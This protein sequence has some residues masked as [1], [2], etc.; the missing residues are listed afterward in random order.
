MIERE[1]FL[2]L[3]FRKSLHSISLRFYKWHALHH[4]NLHLFLSLHASWF[5]NRLRKCSV[6]VGGVVGGWGCNT[7]GCFCPV[8]SGKFQHRGHFSLPAVSLSLPLPLTHT[9]T[10]RHTFSL[11]HTYTH[12]ASRELWLQGSTLFWGR[13][14]KCSVVDVTAVSLP[15][16][17]SS[18]MSVFFVSLSHVTSV[19]PLNVC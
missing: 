3:F 19:S 16:F 11:L 12:M 2:F 4:A 17:L 7:P 5:L 14:R 8:P 18:L 15:F 6:C 9:F 10:C 1:S 13:K